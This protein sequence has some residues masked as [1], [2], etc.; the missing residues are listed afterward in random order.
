MHRVKPPKTQPGSS[1]FMG[2]YKKNNSKMG[3]VP[4][5]HRRKRA[6]ENTNIQAL[7]WG[8]VL[9]KLPFKMLREKGWH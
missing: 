4:P 9:Y 8:T 1:E 6:Q 5:G 7:V 3:A 2:F